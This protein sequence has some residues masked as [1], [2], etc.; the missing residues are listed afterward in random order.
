MRHPSS[1]KDHLFKWNEYVCHKM[2]AIHF[3]T[4]YQFV[5]NIEAVRV[6][7]DCEHECFAV[8]IKSRLCDHI[9]SR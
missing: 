3:G 8:N 9:I 7:H 6:P 4:I 1:R 2:I 5:D